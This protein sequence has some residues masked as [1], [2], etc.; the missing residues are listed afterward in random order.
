MHDAIRKVSAALVFAVIAAGCGVSKDKY[1]AALADADK[2]KK[3][4][5]DESQRVKDCEQKVASLGTKTQTLEQQTATAQAQVDDYRTVNAALAAENAVSM[6]ELANLS[7][8]VTIRVPEKLLF[9]PGSAAIKKEGK[10]GLTKIA[11]AMKSVSGRIFYVAGNTDNKSIKTKQFPSN[12]ELST[13]RALSVVHFFISQGVDPRVLG[14]AGYAQ[15]H[16][17]A[18]NDTAAG[19]ARNRRIDIGI[20]APPSD[21]PTV[22]P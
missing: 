14:V 4:Y 8:L 10:A 3:D 22:K 16:P 7:G 6:V 9:A 5:A 21:L 2:Y 17:I 20:A 18:S 12:W 19:Q 1:D 15:Y 11:N 13:S